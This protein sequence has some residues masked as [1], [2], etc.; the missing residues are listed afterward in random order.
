M[1]NKQATELLQEIHKIGNVKSNIKFSYGIAKNKKILSDEMNLIKESFK[2]ITHND[3]EK[4][5]KE[6]TKIQEKYCIKDKKCKPLIVN[7]QYQFEVDKIEDF[8]KEMEKFNS[9]YVEVVNEIAKIEKENLEFLKQKSNL[10]LFK[11][12]LECFPELT[13]NQMENLILLVREEK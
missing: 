1:T 5:K 2:E 6:K 10:E 8:T 7:G 13:P 9:K 12:D 3:F 11:I 4:F